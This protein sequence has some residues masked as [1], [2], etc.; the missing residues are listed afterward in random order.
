MSSPRSP[1]DSSRS[2]APEL[3]YVGF[4]SVCGTGPVG[5]RVCA[6]GGHPV[7][8]C[9]ECDATW[10]EPNLSGDPTFPAQPSLPCPICSGSLRKPP[11]HWALQDE[12]EAF[13][14]RWAVKGSGAALE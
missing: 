1:S 9:D 3:H 2:G 12:I 10:T 6:N 14:L 11:A 4:C 8:L 13:G 5:I 7:M